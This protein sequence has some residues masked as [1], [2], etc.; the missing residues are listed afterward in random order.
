M[1]LTHNPLVDAV[2]L[3]DTLLNCRQVLAVLSAA[4]AADPTIVWTH[5]AAGSLLLLELV[6]DALAEVERIRQPW[7]KGNPAPGG[8]G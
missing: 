6:D 3:D 8:E 7:A 4:S 1:D 5:A 2:T